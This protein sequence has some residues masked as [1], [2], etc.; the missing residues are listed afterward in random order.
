MPLGYR[1]CGIVEY[2][3][4]CYDLQIINIHVLVFT[5]PY[6]HRHVIRS[7]LWSV[8]GPTIVVSASVTNVIDVHHCLV[9][10]LVSGSM[11]IRVALAYHLL[12]FL[13]A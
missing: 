12:M 7:I 8:F 2:K 4:T 9:Y 1:G 3:I 11:L 10:T 13:D 6:N 5:V